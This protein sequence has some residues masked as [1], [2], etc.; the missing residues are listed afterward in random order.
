MRSSAFERAVARRTREVAGAF[1]ADVRRLREDAGV[2]RSELARA[3]GLDPSYVTEIEDGVARPSFETC[4][5]LSLALGADLSSRLYPTTGP[6]IR[7]R[8]QAAIVEATL[9]ALHPRWKAF[10]E[11]AVQRP[12]R[13]WIDMGL[14]DHAANLFV[15]TEIQSDLRRLEQLIRW[16]E[17]KAAALPSWDGWVHLGDQPLVSRLLIVRNTR[18]NR[19]V[20][21]DHRQLLRTAFPADG[22]LALDA[23]RRHDAWPGA[24]I[25]WATRDRAAPGR[26]RIAARP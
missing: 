5:R 24:A 21:H 23:I 22:E 18:T 25:L 11:V 7:D 6:A 14:Y 9:R 20:A 3:A 17:A 4:V 8:H 15:A 19:T 26:Y 12:S 13:G 1:G 10:T 2:R 16:S